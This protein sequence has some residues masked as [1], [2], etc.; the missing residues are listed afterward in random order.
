MCPRADAPS[1][2]ALYWFGETIYPSQGSLSHTVLFC[3]N[4]LKDVD[5]W[6]VFMLCKHEPSWI[7]GR[8]RK[9]K[10]SVS[11]DFHRFSFNRFGLISD[12]LTR[13]VVYSLLQVLNT[14]LICSESVALI[15]SGN[16]KCDN[17]TK[18]ALLVFTNC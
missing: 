16:M 7:S 14:R 2:L 13:H 4:D 6:P 8:R 1:S 15:K 11:T 3:L 10:K 17:E 18:L 5:R 9:L 12:V